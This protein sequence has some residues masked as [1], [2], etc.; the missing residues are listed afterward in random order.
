MLNQQLCGKSTRSAFF[1]SSF[2][3]LADDMGYRSSLRDALM[4]RLLG[5]RSNLFSLVILNCCVNCLASS[6]Q[7]CECF[8]VSNILCL[9]QINALKF[10]RRIP[11]PIYPCDSGPLQRI[12]Y[13]CLISAL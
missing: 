6:S 5:A 11:T 9:S 3:S 13:Q 8:V 4:H 7:S 2:E 10:K 1:L 12:R